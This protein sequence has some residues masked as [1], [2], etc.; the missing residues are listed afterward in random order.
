M[1][2]PA[3]VRE[4]KGLDGDVRSRLSAAAVALFS[5]QGYRGTSVEEIVAAAG[6]TKGA[7]YHYFSGKDDLLRQIHDTFLDFEIEQAILIGERQLPPDETLRLLMHS[8]LECVRRYPDEIRVFFQ[9]LPSV[10]GAT[11]QA[12]KTKRSRFGESLVEAIEAGMADGTFRRVGPPRVLAYGIIGMC[13]WAYHWF[14]PDGP[15]AASEI[16]EAYAEV[17]L[18]GLREGTI[19]TIGALGDRAQELDLRGRETMRI[20][21][22]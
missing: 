14:R 9:E 10:R 4:V 8:L 22:V 18:T 20:D 12:I 21:G 2:R 17:V 13:S 7:L 15:V 19:G 11:F 3:E 1:K 6:V 16:A 5:E